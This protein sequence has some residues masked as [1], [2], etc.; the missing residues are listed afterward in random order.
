MLKKLQESLTLKKR[1]AD[2]IIRLTSDSRKWG[3]GNTPEEALED[4][5]KTYHSIIKD[6]KRLPIIYIPK[7]SSK[8]K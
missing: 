7:L 5:R 3:C 1:N 8:T 4:L 6:I 2:Y